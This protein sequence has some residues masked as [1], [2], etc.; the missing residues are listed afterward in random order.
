M[1]KSTDQTELGGGTRG[2][3]EHERKRAEKRRETA[4]K[5]TVRNAI[6]VA[7]QKLVNGDYAAVARICKQRLQPAIGLSISNLNAFHDQL[8]SCPLAWD[9]DAL[10]QFLQWP[11]QFIDT[12]DSHYNDENDSL[13]HRQRLRALG[14]VDP[15]TN[16]RETVLRAFK[17]LESAAVAVGAIPNE[18]SQSSKVT[19]HALQ[20]GIQWQPWEYEA[21]D[22]VQVANPDLHPP[23][24]LSIGIPGHGKST[25]V[26]TLVEDAYAA[27]HKI[28]DLLDFDELENAMYDVPS[29]QEVLR[30]KRRRMDLAETFEEHPDYDRPKVEILHPLCQGLCESALPYNKEHGWV[31][32]PFTIPAADIPHDVL[33]AWMPKLTDAREQQLEAA[34]DTLSTQDNWTLEDLRE[35]IV[36]SAADAQVKRGLDSAIRSVQQL[37]FIGDRT[38]ET[39]LEWPSIFRDTETITVFSC[40][41]MGK[42]RH[43]LMVLAYLVFAIYEERMPDNPTVGGLDEKY[44]VAYT[45][46][47]EMQ[48][49][50]PGDRKLK[51][52]DSATAALKSKL[53]T[54]MQKLGEKRRHTDLGVIGDS[55]QWYQI[56]AGVRENIDQVLM[57]NLQA[58]AAQSVFQKLTGERQ[59]GHADSVDEFDVGE[60]AVIGAGRLSTGRKFEMPWSIAPPMCHHLDA[61]T[62]SSGWHARSEYLGDREELRPSPYSLD[63]PDPVDYEERSRQHR[64]REKVD[65]NFPEFLE[66]CVVATSDRD[67]RE[68]KVDVWHA[69]LGFADHCNMELPPNKREFGSWLRAYLPESDVPNGK[70][71]PEGVDDWGQAKAA[72]L[73]CALTESGET[74]RERG[75]GLC[76]EACCTEG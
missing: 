30:R 32:T 54:G 68:F 60:C 44:P 43:K 34:L 42:E 45:V 74:Y 70:K 24:L 4:R 25:A 65:E 75:L 26:D 16:A 5:E 33:K 57:F 64:A 56:N 6:R 46:M 73:C 69:Y 7:S 1:S 23:F 41:L 58:G 22:E 63:D 12:L 17:S 27:G 61:E 36:E 72:Y 55:Q 38:D 62:E 53:V 52:D 2:F 51:G 20:L 13:I 49:V 31:A 67:D 9:R 48:D 8:H 10:F 47:R 18:L 39:T 66:S 14:Y 11:E 37:G 59:K 15:E 76:D 50:A 40:S 35:K 21:P 19:G 3:A 71:R 28:I 29:Q